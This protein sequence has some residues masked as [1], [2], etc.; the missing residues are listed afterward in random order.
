MSSN[1]VAKMHK[2][3]AKLSLENDRNKAI[4]V[5]Y[6][7]ENIT[8]ND[9]VTELRGLL[10]KAKLAITQRD[11]KIRALNDEIISLRQQSRVEQQEPDNTEPDVPDNRVPD[12]RYRIFHPS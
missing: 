9:K 2:D 7:E 5:E 11:A 6:K 8:L 4:I 1:D 3:Y 10:D 12:N